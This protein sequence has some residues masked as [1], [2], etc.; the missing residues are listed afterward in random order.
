MSKYNATQTWNAPEDHM[1]IPTLGSEQNTIVT[2]II[3]QRD[4]SSRMNLC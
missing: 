3:N 4:T 2:H 1:L